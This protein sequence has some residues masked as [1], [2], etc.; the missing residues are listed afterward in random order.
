[1]LGP[2]ILQTDF[3]IEYISIEQYV[4]QSRRGKTKKLLALH[5]ERTLIDRGKNVS[6]M[7]HFCW[8]R[9]F[10]CVGMFLSFAT[11]SGKV[12][13]I[14]ALNTGHAL[15]SEKNTPWCEFCFLPSEFK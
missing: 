4:R 7:W 10:R 9:I 12:C 8:L 14:S 11:F 2:A 15:A 6:R 3:L 13:S 5:L 1:M